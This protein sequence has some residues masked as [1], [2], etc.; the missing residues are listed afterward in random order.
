MPHYS[1]SIDIRLTD[2]QY[3]DILKE[4]DI[5]LPINN[6]NF[7]GQTDSWNW[8]GGYEAEDIFYS[9][10]ELLR[11]KAFIM[12]TWEDSSTSEFKT[13]IYLGESTKKKK[14]VIFEKENVSL[15]WEDDYIA[16]EVELKD[17]FRKWGVSFNDAN[18][19]ILRLI[20]VY[21]DNYVP[22]NRYIPAQ[23]AEFFSTSDDLH[24]FSING[25]R[26][27]PSGDFYYN[28]NEIE[29]FIKAEGGTVARN[30]SG[31]TA[32]LIIGLE[33]KYAENSKKLQYAV[34]YKQKGSP[35]MIVSDIEFQKWRMKQNHE[36][37]TPTE[38]TPS[39]SNTVFF[40]KYPQ[41]SSDTDQKQPIEWIVLEEKKNKKL[42]LSKYILDYKP[43]NDSSNMDEPIW[44]DS[45][46][47]RW[48]NT[49][50][51]NEA[52]SDEEK[53]KIVL[54]KHGQNSIQGMSWCGSTD[55]NIFL[56]SFK[57]VESRFDLDNDEEL[58][59]GTKYAFSKGLQSAIELFGE[60]ADFPDAEKTG[61]WMLRSG[62]MDG[63]IYVH[64]AGYDKDEDDVYEPC[65]IRPALW[66]EKA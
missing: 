2:K 40:G 29:K 50:F 28:R 27:V 44:E 36:H 60:E 51:M 39:D 52:F 35:I 38:D 43:Y 24:G 13:W 5:E 20:G 64:A 18:P 22:E 53:I 59:Q 34:E 9:L 45:D 30:V 37:M 63:Y 14:S 62:G 31:T 6:I 19:E 57:D 47:R 41:D 7:V 65:G 11:D 12:A 15:D 61:C 16:G 55:D 48:L 21:V 8:E 3:W 33:N 58:A 23:Y 1:N 54:D 49:E 4:S 42:L 66:I 56:L 25:K 17:I 32:L 46:I 26:I 10:I